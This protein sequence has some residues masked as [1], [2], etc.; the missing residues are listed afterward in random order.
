M[1]GT[2]QVLGFQGTHVDP[3]PG[4]YCL[5]DVDH[6]NEQINISCNYK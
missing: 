4:P 5:L 3:V 6:V 1:P 2:M